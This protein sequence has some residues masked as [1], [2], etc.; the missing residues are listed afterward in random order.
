MMYRAKIEQ[1]YA[2]RRILPG[3]TF[4]VEPQDVHLL[5]VLG[6]IEPEEFQTREMQAAPSPGYL[7]KRIGRPPKGT[8]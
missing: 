5:T 4:H 8:H 1:V 3:E 7:T 2:E 6:R